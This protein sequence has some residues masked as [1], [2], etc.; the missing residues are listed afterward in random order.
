MCDQADELVLIAAQSE[1]IIPLRH[2]FGFRAV[3]RA[4]AIHE[5]R[6]RVKKLAPHAIQSAVVS[7]I[8]IAVPLAEAP[9]LF[10]SRPVPRVGASAEKVI[11][12]DVQQLP[13][14]PELPRAGIDERFGGQAGVLGR[15]GVLQA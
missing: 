13:E 10:D 7:W 8:N 14:L 5:L 3:L 9:E 4:N 15:Q 12:A 6:W 1:E 11:V 2:S